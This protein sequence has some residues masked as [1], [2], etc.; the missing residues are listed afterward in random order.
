M[1]SIPLRPDGVFRVVARN[2]QVRQINIWDHLKPR[3]K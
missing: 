2:G 3:R 1:I